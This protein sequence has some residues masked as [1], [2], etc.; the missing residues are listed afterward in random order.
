MSSITLEKTTHMLYNTS[1]ASKI[2][3]LQK[4]V[5]EALS[6]KTEG[7]Y[8]AGGTALARYYFQHRISEDLDFFTQQYDERKVAGL[9]EVLGKHMRTKIRLVA[10]QG[11]KTG[12]IN[13]VVYM[14][15][16]KPMGLKLD[17]VE[18]YVKLIEPCKIVDGIPILSLADIF[19]R[20][21]YTVI[22]AVGVRDD[23]GRVV[24]T[25]RQEAKDYY[26]LYF[27]SRTYKRL[28]DFSAD[29]CSPTERESLVHWYRT[30]DR[31]N[32][33]TGLLDLKRPAHAMS[34]SRELEE[35]FRKEIDLL[36]EKEIGKI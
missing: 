8:L 25:G 30:Y 6:G 27:L 2:E 24:S 19:L 33:K 9:V 28:S 36:L 34:D 4:R 22:G 11:R 18:D 32:I 14:V 7:F 13:M 21:I 1:M 12:M 10:Q 26:D 20:K 15:D 29:H 5:L 31:L 16:A 17:F 23:I 3:E 35:H